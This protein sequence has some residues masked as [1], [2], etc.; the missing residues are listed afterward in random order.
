MAPLRSFPELE[1]AAE[2][3]FQ[4]A[5]DGLRQGDPEA[6][7]PEGRRLVEA[8]RELRELQR[9]RWAWGT[10]APRAEPAGPTC[11]CGGAADR[12]CLGCGRHW[13]ARCAPES[14]GKACPG[15]GGPVWAEGETLTPA[16]R[17]P[18]MKGY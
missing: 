3:E 14:G 5:M 1:Q 10:E 12:R 17:N 15:C 18:A 8:H 9:R 13:C 4:A 7:T 2:A 6:N 16:I 11:R